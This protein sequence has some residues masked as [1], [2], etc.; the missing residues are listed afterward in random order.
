MKTS[1]VMLAF[2]VSFSAIAQVAESELPAAAPDRELQN[3]MQQCH[4]QSPEAVSALESNYQLVLF[5]SSHQQVKHEKVFAD[6]AAISPS[7]TPPQVVNQFAV[8]Y[9]VADA[10]VKNAQQ[11]QTV[12]FRY[13]RQMNDCWKKLFAKVDDEALSLES[14]Y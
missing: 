14:L 1:F 8:S 12:D 11:P 7:A 2:F 4:I 10:I 13:L 9:S 3:L 6:V 5:N